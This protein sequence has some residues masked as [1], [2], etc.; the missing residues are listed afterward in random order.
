MHEG[1]R[2]WLP[3]NRT[4]TRTTGPCLW[5]IRA[6]KLGLHSIR[7][8]R[9]F[10]I[11]RSR[12]NHPSVAPSSTR[13]VPVVPHWLEADGGWLGEASPLC[14][15]SAFLLTPFLAINEIYERANSTV[16][17]SEPTPAMNRSLRSSHRETA[18]APLLALHESP[19]RV[20]RGPT[21]VLFEVAKTPSPCGGC[22]LTNRSSSALPSSLLE[23]VSL[24]SAMTL[25][26]LPKERTD[27]V[28]RPTRWSRRWSPRGSRGSGRRNRFESSPRRGGPSAV[29][30]RLRLL[31]PDRHC[32][33][34]GWPMKRRRCQAWE[35]GSLLLV[36]DFESASA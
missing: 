20:A 28:C 19:T 2:S 7:A 10:A 31:V 26:G 35:L 14:R 32:R 34:I 4:S 15:G 24:A 12:R 13:S 36:G 23:W 21:V 5:G 8:R 17:P 18:R 11:S 9:G 33:E 6:R 16:H 25:G 30:R 1:S 29:P 22:V 3:E 27:A